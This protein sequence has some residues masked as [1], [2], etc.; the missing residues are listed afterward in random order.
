MCAVMPF[1]AVAQT[2]DSKKE[3][4]KKAKQEVK[5]TFKHKF[6]TFHLEA[7]A[8]L[9]YD[10]DVTQWAT[11]NPLHPTSGGATQH[12]YGFRG[13]YFNFLL[14]VDIGDHFSYFIRQRIIPV[15]GYT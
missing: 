13:D 5:A 12:N 15:K 4:N 7:R 3:T 9:E 11:I 8:A 1:Y 14:G 2:Q 6:T 10:Y